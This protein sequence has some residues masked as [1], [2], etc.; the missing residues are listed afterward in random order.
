MKCY[1]KW[2]AFLV[3]KAKC[4]KVNPNLLSPNKKRKPTICVLLEKGCPFRSLL[5]EHKPRKT[6]SGD[7]STA[8]NFAQV[9]AAR[10]W[11]CP[12]A[13]SQD[14]TRFP[15]LK[16]TRPSC[17]RTSSFESILPRALYNL[18]RLGGGAGDKAVSTPL[19]PP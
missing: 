19:R 1:I 17:L 15:D 5:L 3:W 7:A 4:N 13:G 9:S 14:A 16:T 18:Q 8:P 12:S 2:Y 6:K 10:T 11:L